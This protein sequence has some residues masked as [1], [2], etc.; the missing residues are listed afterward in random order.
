LGI[1][2]I[3]PL[4]ILGHFVR[5]MLAAL[6]TESPSSFRY[7]DHFCSRAVCTMESVIKYLK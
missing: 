5:L 1:Q 7:I 4:L 3:L 6:L 2:G